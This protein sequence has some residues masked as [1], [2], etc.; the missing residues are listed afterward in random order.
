MSDDPLRD[1][2]D[3]L[4]SWAIPQRILDQAAASPWPAPPGIFIRR[5]AARHRRPRG[6]SFQRALEALPAN[7]SVLDVGAGA[8]AASIPLLTRARS[9]C[10]VDQDPALLDA[11]LKE[12]AGDREKVTTLAG[13]WPQVAPEVP[14]VDV[15]VCAHVLYNVPDLRP[16]INALG[17]H[18]RRRVVIEITAQHPVSRLNPLWKRFHGLDRPTRPNWED[19]TRAI[20]SICKDV[21]VER[22]HVEADTTLGT[23]EEMVGF[24]CRRICLSPE[25]EADVAAALMEQ[26]AEPSDPATWSPP[27]REVVT[28]WWDT[29]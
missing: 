28:L 9:L 23:W 7:G 15:T 25:R 6:I 12:A 26:G 4:A 5:A 27:D 10:A 20:G 2:R 8:G 17:A 19:A 18:T 21:R 3:H 22:E 13:S 29:G 11:L 1:W 24:T 14:I 16:F